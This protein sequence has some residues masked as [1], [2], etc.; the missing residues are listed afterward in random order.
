MQPLLTYSF[1]TGYSHP[2]VQRLKTVD[3]SGRYGND[4]HHDS[5]VSPRAPRG[6]FLLSELADW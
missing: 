1:L 3:S 2:V 6:K 4:S 5:L